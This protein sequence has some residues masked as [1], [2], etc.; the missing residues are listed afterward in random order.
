MSVRH[1]VLGLLIER[2]SYGYQL[3]K[4]LDEQFGAWAW[5]SSGVYTAL[6]QLVRDGDVRS[7][8]KKEMGATARGA[9]RVVYEATP[10]GQGTFAAWINEST[11]LSPVRDGLDLKILLARPEFLPSLIDQTW[12]QEQQCI[13]HL[14]ALRSTRPPSAGLSASWEEAAVVL[15]SRAEIKQLEARIETLQETRS[16]MATILA[17]DSERRPR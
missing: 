9:P 11:P 16:V 2:P 4:R 10:Q 8:G 5:Q 13:D 3:T 17:R 7:R 6:D 12:A 1:A 15:K 14:R